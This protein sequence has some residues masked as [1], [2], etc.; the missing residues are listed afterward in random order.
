MQGYYESLRN[1]TINTFL[2]N[3]I[4]LEPLNLFFYTWVFLEELE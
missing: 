3:L 4:Y 2:Y 1:W